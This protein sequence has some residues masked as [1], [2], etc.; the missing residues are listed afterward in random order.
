MASQ[1]IRSRVSTVVLALSLAGLL[2]CK[3]KR[4]DGATAEVA[5]R[6]SIGKT[7]AGELDTQGS[8]EGEQLPGREQEPD[9]PRATALTIARS[10]AASPIA[11]KGAKS[12]GYNLD[13]IAHLFS[14]A[15]TAKIPDWGA[16]GHGEAKLARDDDLDTAWRCEFSEQPAGGDASRPCVLGL[17]L[18]EQAKVEV[19]RLYTAAGPRYRDYAGH[20]R[21]AKVRVHTE[22]GYVDASLADGANHAYVRFD[23]PIETQWLAI[24]VLE[25]HAGKDDALV[26]LAEVEVYGTDGA[27]RQPI[28]LDP[29]FAW[30]GWETTTWSASANDHTIRQVFLHFSRPSATPDVPPSSRRLLRASAVFGRASDDYLLFERLHGTD[31]DRTRGS[32]VL[33]DKRNRMHYPLGEL[34]GA[35]ANVYRH[36]AGRGFAVGWIGD[37]VFT[38]KGVVEEAGMLEWRRPPSQPP[39]NGEAQL[40]EWGFET[41]PLARAQAI[42]EAI[43]GCH[44]ATA[45]ELDPLLT[46]AKFMQ[47]GAEHPRDWLVCTVGDDTLYASAA[48]GKRARAYQL[49]DGKLI[50]KHESKHEHARALRLRRVGDRLLVELSA[51]GD[52]STLLWAEPGRLLELGSHASLF[53]R[54]PAACSECD[55]NWP[56][57]TA[58]ASDESIEG[59]ELLGD[60]D[61][62]PL[63]DEGEDANETTPSEAGEHSDQLPPPPP[64]A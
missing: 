39:L 38:V 4:N 35:G 21:V 27:P 55:D 58:Q 48:C 16:Q 50:G 9:D 36:A 23:A 2:A 43:P 33:F 59:A 41:E 46:A 18:P 62:D 54:P 61:G 7:E 28:E 64:P 56:N 63:V 20:P 34:G 29:D 11:G 15:A 40:R 14:L 44:R 42:G 57:P 13:K 32:Y 12:L 19:L 8:D 51:A 47:V 37:G 6:A 10:P 24:E 17:A 3:D 30:V 22:A 45:G 52:N 31:C 53:V 60:G 5:E 1:A 49:E 25:T 26:H